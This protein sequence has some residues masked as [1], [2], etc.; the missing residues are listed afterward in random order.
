M[1][2]GREAMGN[3][4]KA[5]CCQSSGEKITRTKKGEPEKRHLGFFPT[6]ARIRNSV[7]GGEETDCGSR[8]VE[9]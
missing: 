6:T 9:E 8:T 4:K 5:L 2:R 7:G 1:D 3:E